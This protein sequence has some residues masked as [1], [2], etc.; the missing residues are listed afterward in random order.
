[1]HFRRKPYIFAAGFAAMIAATALAAPVA[2]ASPVSPTN[3]QYSPYGPSIVCPG[4]QVIEKP[5]PPANFDPLTASNDNLLKYSYPPRPSDPK[6]HKIWLRFMTQPIDWGS[7]DPP[8]TKHLVPAVPTRGGLPAPGGGALWGGY[9]PN[10]HAYTDAES[11]IT[12]PNINTGGTLYEWVGVNT[13]GT[14]SHPLVQA[15]G[16]YE[17][18]FSANPFIWYEVYPQTPP[19]IPAGFVNHVG[20]T[21]LIFIHVNLTSG[22]GTY[23]L[24]DLSANIDHTYAHSGAGTVD[25]HAA[26]IGEAPDGHA[27]PRFDGLGFSDAQA[28]APGLGWVGLSSLPHPQR[29]MVA[30]N[31]HILATT[32]ALSG[33][34]AFGLTWVQSS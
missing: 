8:G 28:Y 19:I 23:H 24:V 13:A 15:G 22:I 6:L 20:F 18:A 2:G 21:D 14:T 26:F 3:S 29:N 27:I 31:G 4:G 33:S 34:G 10:Q 25:G 9:T 12:I 16:G 7:C 11:Y 1:M 32:G 17:D 5:N 30:P